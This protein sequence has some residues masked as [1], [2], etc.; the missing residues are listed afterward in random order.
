MDCVALQ[1]GGFV[2]DGVTGDSDGIAYTVE[3]LDG[4]WDSPSMRIETTE[5][6][7][8]GEVITVARTNGRALAL[9]MTAHVPPVGD[10]IVTEALGGLLCRTAMATVEAAFAGM[11]Y[12]AVALT[13]SDPV[14]TLTA[15]VKLV[16]PAGEGPIQTSIV[17]E[18]VMVRFLIQ[19]L[20]PDP[21]F[22]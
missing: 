6:Q 17:G 15:N 13:V 1:V 11:V 10:G 7:P 14:N 4:W 19:M 8:V 3:N 22:V 16:D 5:V 2:A 12:T 21:T 20:A 9:T 18:S